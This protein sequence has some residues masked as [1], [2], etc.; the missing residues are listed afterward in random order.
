MAERNRIAASGGEHMP[1]SMH[2]LADGESVCV[3]MLARMCKEVWGGHPGRVVV[4]ERARAHPSSSCCRHCVTSA[5]HSVSV[6]DC[7]V[8]YNESQWSQCDR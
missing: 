8:N 3:N 2:T 7:T 4:R 6:H 5:N 1:A